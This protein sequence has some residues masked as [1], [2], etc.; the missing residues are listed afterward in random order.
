MGPGLEWGLPEAR[1]ATGATGE[2]RAQAARAASWGHGLGL[3]S[4]CSD[5]G[6]DALGHSL[7][8]RW[9]TAWR[10]KG[11]AGML[12]LQIW[13]AVKGGVRPPWSCACRLRPCLLVFCSCW[14]WDAWFSCELYGSSPKMCRLP[15]AGRMGAVRA[16]VLREP[17][18]S[19]PS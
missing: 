1:L 8:T 9:T 17:A 7:A 2:S 16:P 18:R 3:A 4:S 15:P 5:T 14:A 11:L 12:G 13:G 10:V 19:L 6:Q